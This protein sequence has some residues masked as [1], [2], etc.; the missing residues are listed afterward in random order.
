MIAQTNANNYYIGH[1]INN[2]IRY[3]AS[4]GGLGSLLQ[5]YLLSSGEYGTSITFRFNSGKCMYEPYL[6]YNAE[7]VNI[8]GSIYQDINIA[9][10]VRE[11]LSLIKGGIV[12]SC[13]PCQVSAI[14]NT[15]DKANIPNFI[16]SFCCSGQMTIE[17]TW[18]YYELLG[19]NKDDVVNMQYRG[20][21]WPSGIQ[22]SLKNGENIYKDNWT[23]PWI[24]IH[25]SGLYRPKRCYYCKFDTSYKSDISLAD[26]WL[27]KYRK[28]DKIGNTLFVVNSSLGRDIL[29]AISEKGLFEYVDTDYNS[30]YKAQKPNVEKA[31]RILNQEKYLKKI[32]KLIEN[33]KIRSYF[34]KDVQRMRLFIKLRQRIQYT[35]SFENIKN[36]IMRIVHRIIDKCRYLLLSRKIGSH[37]D[38]FTVR[39]GVIACKPE[40]LH[41]GKGVSIGA[42]TFLNA[43]TFNNGTKY[44]PIIK[45]GEGTS[46]GKNCTLSAIN[47][48]EIGKHVLFAAHVH[49]TDHS[50]GYEDISRPIAPQ[51]LITKGPV[52]IEDDCWLGF[53]C[54]ILS[55][56]H[57]GKH[58]VVGA[59]AVVTKDVPPYSI[60]A[61]NPARIVK[62]YN[63]ETEQWELVKKK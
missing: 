3:K 21:G 60:V 40:C 12:I 2:I 48:V 61:G 15:L 7:D 16:I 55:G 19:I 44:N 52:V 45:I 22:I 50:H 20:N 56:V 43:V 13:P 4:S 38:V 8:C 9:A 23:E 39:G 32:T 53:G 54:E 42:N 35:S 33:P 36:I 30:F 10:Y 49:I 59:R 63:F 47:K 11:N 31:N 29:N 5:K 6:I 14:R 17:G 62:Q 24:T 27:N 1:A 41:F 28:E 58:C 46:I 18:K 37:D 26:P 25:S 57:I 34:T 51:T